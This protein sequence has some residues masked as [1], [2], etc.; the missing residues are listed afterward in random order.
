MLTKSTDAAAALWYWLPPTLPETERPFD[1]GDTPR[2]NVSVKSPAGA[3]GRAYTYTKHGAI[4]PHPERQTW[5]PWTVNGHDCCIV[6]ENSKR[7]Q[8]PAALA[9]DEMLPG[10]LVDFADGSKWQVP[11]VRMLGGGTGLPQ[12]RTLEPDGT[13]SWSPLERYAQLSAAVDRMYRHNTGETLE[14]AI[15]DNE[16]DDAIGA[17]LALN[18]HIGLPELLLLDLMEVACWRRAVLAMMDWPAVEAALEKKRTG[19]ATP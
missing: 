1:H 3:I 12:R 11:V 16:I 8:L 7:D 18:Y 19:E 15:T 6:L 4:A 13:R 14:P 9:R 17:G 5:I 10:H 2:T